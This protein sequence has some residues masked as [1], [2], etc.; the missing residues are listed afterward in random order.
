MT[1]SHGSDGRAMFADGKLVA[2]LVRL[3]DAIH[4]D[5]RGS[6]AAA[7]RL[8]RTT[9]LSTCSALSSRSSRFV[10]SKLALGPPKL[11]GNLGNSG[12]K[13]KV[14]IPVTGFS[15]LHG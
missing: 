5:G 13:S 6:A 1:N 9:S 15:A 12:V 8:C 4:K 3:D 14:N 11:L 7:I 2:V 10:L